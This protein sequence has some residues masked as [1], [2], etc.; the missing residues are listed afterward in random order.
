MMADDVSREIETELADL[1]R[2]LTEPRPTECL[3][4][5]LLRLI[6]EFG[7]DGTFRWAIRWRDVCASQPGRLLDQLASRG[8]CCDCEI[9]MNV[10]P[11]YPDVAAPLPCAGV[12]KPGSHRPCQL[13]QLPRAA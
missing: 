12:P 10:F 4:C 7:C 9:L 3:R 1:S 6:S 5:Y 2:R 11:Y 8:G 13:R